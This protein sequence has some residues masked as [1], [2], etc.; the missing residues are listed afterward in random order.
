MVGSYPC[1]LLHRA[2]LSYGAVLPGV[3]RL[4][5]QHV[6]YPPVLQ[7]FL[8]LAVLAVEDLRH[9]RPERDAALYGRLDEFEGYLF[10]LVRKPGSVFLPPSNH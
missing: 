4:Y 10:G 5:G 8:E 7:A 1:Y 3:G 9:H 2:G 6:G